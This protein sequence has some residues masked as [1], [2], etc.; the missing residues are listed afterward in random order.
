MATLK[1][2]RPGR[3]AALTRRPAAEEDEPLTA[4]ER[5]ALAR[6]LKDTEDR[7]RFVLVSVSLPGFSL[8]YRVQDDAWSFDDPSQAT[9]FK[10][11]AAAQ[12]IKALL[13]PGVHIVPC[14][15]DEDGRLVSSSVAQR[16]IGRTRL[17]VLPSWRRKPAARRAGRKR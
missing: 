15:V 2:K 7:S 8:Y 9:L 4:A 6:H 14:R 13:R 12:A 1:R 16:K 5:R 10:R 3:V 17:A 11:R